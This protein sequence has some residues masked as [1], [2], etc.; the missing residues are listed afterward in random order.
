MDGLDFNNILSDEEAELLFSDGQTNDTEEKTNEEAINPEGLFEEEDTED[1][2]S[3]KKEIKETTEVDADDLFADPGSVGSGDNSNE[4][5]E[6]TTKGT[7]SSTKNF[8]SSIAKAFKED[9]IF[10]NLDDEKLN[11]EDAESFHNLIE[12]QIKSKLDERMKRIDHALNNNVES[13]DIQKYESALGYLNNI[14]DSDL[15]AETEEGETLRKK[16]IYQDYKNKGFTHER[17][18]KA[19]ERSITAGTDIDDAKDALIETT[20]YFSNEYDELIN[21]AEKAKE[22]ALIERNKT[23]DELR[24]SILNDKKVFGDVEVSKET[25]E[26]VIDVISKPSK[27]DPETGEYLT[28]LQVYERDNKNDFIKN[29]GL[30]YT[31]TNGFKDI[32][33]LVNSKVKKEVKKG[34]RELEHTINNTSR[35]SDGSLKYVSGVKDDP[36]SAFNIGD[37]DLDLT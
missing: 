17:A 27:R 29:I 2:D 35:N 1:G 4:E 34:I 16:I 36:D 6:D 11:V 12:E 33:N 18:L 3:K 21:K 7:G 10:P 26:R 30:L 8:Y 24:K 23:A 31:L 5:R 22:E 19:V 28:E 37:F 14:K 15:S 13:S 25:R 32:N 9:G 20:N